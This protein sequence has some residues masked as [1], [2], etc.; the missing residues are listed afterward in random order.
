[1]LAFLDD[2]RA[3]HPVYGYGWARGPVQRDGTILCTWATDA[4]EHAAE[5]ANGWS[6]YDAADVR[7]VELVPCV[8]VD[9]AVRNYIDRERADD[10]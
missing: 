4:D 10:A 9:R 5:A 3:W 8:Q 7:L 2:R 6:L 1:V